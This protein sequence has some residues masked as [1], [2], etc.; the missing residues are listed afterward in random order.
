[1]QIRSTHTPYPTIARTVKPQKAVLFGAEE[2]ASSAGDEAKKSDVTPEATST[3]KPSWLRRFWNA[4][5]PIK[6]LKQ[7]FKETFSVFKGDRLKST[8]KSIAII[9]T[10]LT[11]MGALA[12]GPFSFAVIPLYL[13]GALMWTVSWGFFEGLFQTPPR[14]E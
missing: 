4:F 11:I 13:G 14:D 8:L 10:I 12:A 7:A 9:T 1:M 3:H 5:S 6:R 2:A